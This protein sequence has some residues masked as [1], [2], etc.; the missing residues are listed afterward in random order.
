[1]VNAVTDLP[2]IRWEEFLALDWPHEWVNGVAYAM[3]ATSPRHAQICARLAAQL[4][5]RGGCNAYAAGLV[6][7]VAELDRGFLPDLTIVCGTPDEASGRP[8]G[9]T[10]PSI[11]F[12]V[13]SPSTQVHDRTTKLE[14][15]RRLTSLEAYVLLHQDGGRAEAHVRG[16]DGI[17][18]V[19]ERVGG[20]LELPRGFRVELDALR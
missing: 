17:W 1:M 4:S 9:V 2:V 20:L 14:A 7:Y 6:V 5:D 11:V 16:A 13:L 18:T 19:E 15:Y 10:N 3:G 8:G 12:E